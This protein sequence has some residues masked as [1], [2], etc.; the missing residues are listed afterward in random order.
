[1][2][3]IARARGTTGLRV[4]STFSGCGGSCLG[5]E[6]AGFDVVFANEF[7]EE[8]R[9]T[10]VKNHAASVFLDPR[11]IRSVH[12]EEVL[13]RA[14]VKA[15]ELD[16]FEGSPPCSSFSM[17]GAREKG[18]G[19]VKAYCVDPDTKVLGA[20]LRYHRA[21][22]LSVGDRL[23][24]FE[25]ENIGGKGGR[26]F[27]TTTIEHTS[28][29]IRPSI[30]IEFDDGTVTTCSTDHRWLVVSGSNLRWKRARS[31]GLGDEL[32]SVGTWST[33]ESRD[34]G[35]LAGLFDGEGSVS[36]SS[37][38][39]SVTMAQKPGA[40]LDRAIRLLRARGFEV[41]ES[42]S[43]PVVNITI[44]GGLPE[45]LRF[46]GSIRPERL[47]EKSASVYDGVSVKA[48][49]KVRVRAITALGDREVIAITTKH[50]TFIADGLLSHNSGVKQRTDD[51]FFEWLRLLEGVKPKT[52]I[53]E[54]VSGFVR[55][56]AFGYFHT[57]MKRLEA[58]GYV[59][60]A[61]ELDAQWLGVPQ[62]RG[63]V[64]LVGV[65]RD[66]AR[67]LGIATSS[68]VPYPKPFARAF[69]LAEAIPHIIGEPSGIE[70]TIEELEAARRAMVPSLDAEW[71]KLRPGV[72]SEKYF[73]L[74]KAPVNKPS[75]CIT[76]KGGEPAAS[77]THP[78]ERRKFTI[79]EL[80]RI[81]GF[82]D[83]FELTGT[84][85]QQWERLARSVP[86]PMM[87]AI[88]RELRDRVF[89]PLGLV[90]EGWIEASSAP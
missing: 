12:P 9:A 19:Q 17:V 39:R 55:G 5:L 83:D 82:P 26:R 75:P 37:A 80:R 88:G 30:R 2:A 84:F 65:R 74:I 57:V 53:A 56:K 87:F 27:A 67:E 64:I 40:V 3:A 10:Y 61:R 45:K 23:V 42:T 22:D 15:G 89:A 50:A 68:D 47:L 46:L 72:W 34:A 18:W 63:R 16:V 76:V 21:G 71:N 29:L 66:L 70:P 31:I 28:R 90:R 32:L 58:A 1:M 7:I 11:D 24:G 77:V 86:P 62:Q 38:T 52:F 69:T 49:R 44:N 25:E 8:A 59:A 85:A 13:E 73:N 4:A 78:L 41:G 36:R 51:L 79:R 14:G 48:T 43:R 81:C 60:A 35:Y 54:N 6:M 20:D 33:D